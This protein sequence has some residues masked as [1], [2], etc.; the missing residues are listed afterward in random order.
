VS[1]FDL[2]TQKYQLQD[3]FVRKY[4]GTDAHGKVL[5]DLVPTGAVPAFM[6]QLEE[7]GVT[8]PDPVLEL[9]RRNA[10]GQAP[11]HGAS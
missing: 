11:F 4:H 6:H 1:G 2:E 7:H 5:S 10:G 3:I 9:M 8:L